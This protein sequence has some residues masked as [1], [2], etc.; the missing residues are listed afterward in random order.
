MNRFDRPI[1]GQSL[2]TPPKNAPYE[3][4]P[5]ITDP[6]Q[7]IQIHLARLNDPERMED[8]MMYLE[9]GV[10]IVTLVEGILRSAVMSGVHSVD[11]SLTVAPV[12]HEFIKSTAD[13][14]GVSYEEG[15]ENKEEKNLRRYA[16]NAILAKSK[17]A[18]MKIDPKETARNVSELSK[19][20][21][22]TMPEEEPQMET[23]EP[24]G[25]MARRS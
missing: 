21:E 23:E 20:V 24:R 13:A 12:L 11:L 3:R 5:E 22:E 7:A 18:E 17:M 2:T 10:D 4:P 14:M 19:A 16:K 6:E 8:V 1:P 25:L 15:F 9:I